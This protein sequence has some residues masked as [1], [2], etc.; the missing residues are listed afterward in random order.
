MDTMEVENTIGL[1]EKFTNNQGT[2]YAE[3]TECKLSDTVQS[4][5]MASRN[6]DLFN[7]K[8]GKKDIVIFPTFEID[9]EILSWLR[10]A[11]CRGVNVY[12]ITHAEKKRWFADILIN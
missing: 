4:N 1:C 7:I 5:N 2:E 12:L 8:N 3:Y 10:L 6:A 9:E 11:L